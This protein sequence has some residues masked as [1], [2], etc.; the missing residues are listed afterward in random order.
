V[1]WL[2]WASGI[3]LGFGVGFIV[4]RNVGLSPIIA[5]LNGAIAEVQAETERS[6]VNRGIR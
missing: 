6:R 4:G 3:L 5:K 1:G 2:W